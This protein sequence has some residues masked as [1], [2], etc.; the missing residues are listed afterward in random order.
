MCGVAIPA[1]DGMVRC[2]GCGTSAWPCINAKQTTILVNW[3][4][5]RVLCVYAANYG[6]FVRRRPLVEAIVLR[7]QRQ[8]PKLAE[9]EP[10]LLGADADM[11]QEELERIRKHKTPPPREGL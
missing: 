10:L 9:D 1:I 2:P 3:H 8:H 7:I 5:L 6:R 4:E 11:S